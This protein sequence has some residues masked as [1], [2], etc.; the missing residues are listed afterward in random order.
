MTV[1]VEVG[2]FASV[3]ADVG[4]G[5]GPGEVAG[6][7]GETLAGSRTAMR[8]LSSSI[9]ARSAWAIAS[10]RAAA[11]SDAIAADDEPPRVRVSSSAAPRPLAEADDVAADD[12]EGGAPAARPGQPLA[13]VHF[14][15]CADAGGGG[16]GAPAAAAAIAAAACDPDAEG[17]GFLDVRFAEVGFLAEIGFLDAFLAAPGSFGDGRSSS[18]PAPRRS[19]SRSR[20]A[21][22][23]SSLSR[24][25]RAS[26]AAPSYVAEGIAEA[27]ANAASAMEPRRGNRSSPSSAKG[28][29]GCSRDV[30][31]DDGIADW[32]A[33]VA[34]SG[35][36]Q[37]E[38]QLELPFE[39]SS[40][41]GG[42]GG[43][44]GGGAGGG[45]GGAGGADVGT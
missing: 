30:A 3:D 15:L 6:S 7:R 40:A 38:N 14:A 1:G 20:R 28:D 44:G 43:A 13:S 18:D 33:G 22:R 11:F 35:P 39:V 41:G 26:S 29:A 12:P 23:F 19:R 42:G 21:A 5:S 31:S 4:F 34:S 37:P 25:R 17:G 9:S 27:G 16:G 24:R 2:S 36:N 10:A 8:L 32:G 45:G